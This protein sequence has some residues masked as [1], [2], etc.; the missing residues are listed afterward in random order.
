MNLNYQ[1]YYGDTSQSQTINVFPLTSDLSTSQAMYSIGPGTSYNN[2]QPIDSGLAFQLRPSTGNQKVLMKKGFGKSVLDFIGSGTTNSNF[3]STFK[4]VVLRYKNANEGS[5]IRTTLAGDRT[6]IRIYYKQSSGDTSSLYLSMNT[7][8]AR[9]SLINGDRNATPNLSGLKDGVTEEIDAQQR[10]FVQSGIGLRTKIFFPSVSEWRSKLG[11]ISINRAELVI[12][13]D[14]T[15]S[16]SF[17]PI[18]NLFLVKLGSDG[19]AKTYDPGN[20]NLIEWP[21][22]QEGYD[23]HG[24]YYPIQQSFSN[25]QYT[26]NISNYFQALVYGTED[27]YGLMIASYPTSNLASVNR[28]VAGPGYANTSVKFKVYYTILK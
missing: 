22:Q 9:Y 26:F 24:A 20:G 6:F 11:N 14:S 28:V 23:V 25:A 16:K 18:G 10:V 7:S 5:V 12:Q 27:N 1:Y 2:L 8:G 13:Y 4:G 17:Y 19:N 3:I 21:V 15:V